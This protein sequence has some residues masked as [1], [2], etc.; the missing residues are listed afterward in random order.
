MVPLGLLVLAIWGVRWRDDF[1]IRG[2]PGGL[3]SNATKA[4]ASGLSGPVKC[5]LAPNPSDVAA[6]VIILNLFDS[7]AVREVIAGIDGL[8]ET[9]CREKIIVDT[10]TNHF[11][12]VLPFYG[13]IGDAGGIY[14]EAPVL[15]SVVPASQGAL[16]MLVSGDKAAYETTSPR[17][18]AKT[19]FY[20]EKPSLAT[21][22]KLI[23]NLV[24]GSFM[25][26][27]A[28]AVALGDEIGIER[29]NFWKYSE[30]GRGIRWC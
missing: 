15:G 8:F 10:T 3:E 30:Q 11:T 25:A 29:G 19:I 18:L 6:E 17:S 16:T 22:I 5:S 27:I 1:A 14:V 12:Q 2:S 23:N 7:I 26:T 21:R 24:L 13:L 9:D 4:Q 28:E 20:L